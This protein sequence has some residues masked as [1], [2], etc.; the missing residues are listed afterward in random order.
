MVTD[1]EGG[2]KF[3]PQHPRLN[4]DSKASASEKRERSVSSEDL[5]VDKGGELPAEEA[6]AV[7]VAE[8]QNHDRNARNLKG[9]KLGNRKLERYRK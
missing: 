8:G 1:Q 7:A 4:D 9:R 6:L 2:D 5:V 3:V